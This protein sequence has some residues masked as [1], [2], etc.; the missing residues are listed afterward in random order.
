MLFQGG[1]ASAPQRIDT[2]ETQIIT[3]RYTQTC[4][5]LCDWF[6][7]CWSERLM[8][9]GLSSGCLFNNSAQLSRNTFVQSAPVWP[10]EHGDTPPPH[11]IPYAMQYKLRYMSS[12]TGNILCI[13]SIYTVCRTRAEQWEVVAPSFVLICSS[14]NLNCDLSSRYICIGIYRYTVYRYTGIYL[15]IFIY[16]YIIQTSENCLLNSQAPL[17]VW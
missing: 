2:C 6:I 7:H 9:T 12:E 8:F 4:W 3:D 5:P 14:V 13:Y 1:E 16:N 15:Y 17:K 11:P 10:A